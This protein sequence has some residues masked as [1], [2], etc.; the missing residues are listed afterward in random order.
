M[1]KRENNPAVK[2]LK[3]LE[4]KIDNGLF[5]ANSTTNF[6]GKYNSRGKLITVTPKILL[7]TEFHIR[8]LEMFHKL[9]GN[10]GSMSSNFQPDID[11]A[12]RL[13]DAADTFSERY[14]TKT[15]Q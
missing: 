13:Q 7:S 11:Y 3:R 9:P 12:K 15:T 14:G 2:R 1:D 6:F 5:G 10:S 8:H 4:R